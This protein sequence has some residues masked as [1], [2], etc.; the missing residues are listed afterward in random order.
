MDGHFIP[1]SNLL[2]AMSP[3]WR[4]FTDNIAMVQFQHRMVGYTLLGVTLVQALCV[5]AWAPKSRAKR[6]AFHLFGIVFFQACLGIMTLLLVVPIWAG[7]VHQAFA[8]FV[9]AEMVI[10]RESVSRSRTEAAS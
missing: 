2:L 6:R 9:L 4:N 3:I 5:M 8:M 1:S 10:Y 7:L